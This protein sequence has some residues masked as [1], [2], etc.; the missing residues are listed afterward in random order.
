MHF[1]M[2][3]RLTNQVAM[4]TNIKL[5]SKM[6]ITWYLRAERREDLIAQ[7]SSAPTG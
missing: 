2:N 5:N 3:I 4:L 6:I 1:S 7:P